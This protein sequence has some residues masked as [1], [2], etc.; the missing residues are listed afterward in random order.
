MALTDFS[1]YIRKGN[2]AVAFAFEKLT[3]GSAT[4]TGDDGVFVLSTSTYNTTGLVQGSPRTLGLIATI[5]V[6]GGAMRY[7]VDG[8]VPT[9]AQGLVA[10]D[11]DIVTIG[12]FENLRQARFVRLSSAAGDPEPALNIQYWAYKV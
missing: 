6:D 12:G 7:L 2:P 9:T 1:H 5:F 11:Q 10:N 3:V 4:A 8:T